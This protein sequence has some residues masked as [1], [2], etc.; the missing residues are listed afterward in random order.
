MGDNHSL[1][2][3]IVF[4]MSLRI[5][6][7]ILLCVALA[8][9][10]QQIEE[11]ASVETFL[12]SRP[13]AKQ[14]E[15]ATAA[16]SGKAKKLS[17]VKF[18]ALCGAK[19][20]SKSYSASGSHDLTWAQSVK[21]PKGVCA[22]LFQEK[23]FKGKFLK[24]TGPTTV[25]CLKNI[26]LASDK[27]AKKSW[28]KNVRSLKVSACAA[29]SAKEE[30]AN[31]KH[32]A[33]AEIKA[34]T[35]N[36]YK[37]GKSLKSIAAKAIAD[38]KSNDGKVKS[39][40]A[41]AA[42]AA[43]VA[44]K[45]KGL[46]VLAA[47]GKKADGAASA[48]LDPL[49]KRIT[50]C[51][52]KPGFKDA[53]G[54][55]CKTYTKDGLKLGLCKKYG[56]KK[57]GGKTANES[58]CACN[59][60]MKNL[61]PVPKAEKVKISAKDKAFLAAKKAAGSGVGP[62]PVNPNWY[63]YGKNHKEAW[64]KFVVPYPKFDAKDIKTWH[65][66]GMP[67]DDDE[68]NA[69]KNGA[70]KNNVDGGLHVVH[71]PHKG[72]VS[73]DARTVDGY[74]YIGRRRRRIGAGF[75]TPKKKKVKRYVVCRRSAMP[76][77]GITKS[78]LTGKTPGGKPRCTHMKLKYKK[79][80]PYCKK[81]TCFGGKTLKD[82]KKGCRKDNLCIGFTWEHGAK[83]V[84]GGCYLAPPCRFFG[85]ITYDYY[86]KDFKCAKVPK[87]KAYIPH[88]SKHRPKPVPPLKGYSSAS[89][90][91]FEKP[92]GAAHALEKV[93]KKTREIAAVMH[94]DLAK[95]KVVKIKQDCNKCVAEFKAAGG[96][97]LYVVR[98]KDPS[99]LIPK[100]CSTCNPIHSCKSTKGYNKKVV[101][102]KVAK[103][104]LAKKIKK[105]LGH[106]VSK[107]KKLSV[108]R[109][110]KE[111]KKEEAKEKA[112]AKEVKKEVKADARA[113]LV[114]KIEKKVGPA[115]AAKVAANMAIAKA[116]GAVVAKDAAIAG[117]AEVAS[118]VASKKVSE[119]SFV[120]IMDQA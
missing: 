104:V 57:F 27:T 101:S 68:M 67:H 8:L 76:E 116:G 110:Y 111:M 26:A 92:K 83:K 70:G 2:R 48:V 79:K 52:D 58:C 106:P 115:M 24:V 32:A 37:A 46:P 5:G 65:K 113:A 44:A 90:K 3:V 119:E 88:V 41:S 4:L 82:V 107:K 112:E 63:D 80:W 69:S 96:C 6:I 100:G 22:H 59:G 114:H 55:G 62:P 102:G 60:G 1:Q 23:S 12:L 20:G 31:K 15:D 49:A 103:A 105:A 117:M 9:A 45:V 73:D 13:G 118:N 42:D 51:V 16:W 38:V 72:F 53:K 120:E 21:V 85:S 43:K 7:G 10:A 94:H 75:H 19:G 74:Y 71:D 36:A 39:G 84:G 33:A 77:V 50:V 64:K 109:T 66:D 34:L 18:Y 78:K 17:P 35:K 108:K 25:S 40:K 61:V 93:S 28:A 95:K 29:L 14:A 91:A 30:N 86:V 97:T 89:M 47:A 56:K 11:D 87:G 98:R 99:H 54:R 81:L